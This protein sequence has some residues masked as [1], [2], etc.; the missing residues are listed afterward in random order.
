MKSNKSS[1]EKLFARKRTKGVWVG[2]M[3]LTVGVSISLLAVSQSTDNRQLASDVNLN[4]SDSQLKTINADKTMGP[5]TEIGNFSQKLTG[6]KSDL[7]VKVGNIPTTASTDR[8]K[9]K[10]KKTTEESREGWA[11]TNLP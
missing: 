1:H 7:T 4:S 2:L 11:R 8:D 9:G 6:P 10:G 3:L 5:A